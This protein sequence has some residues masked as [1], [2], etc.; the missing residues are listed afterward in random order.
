MCYQYH[1]LRRTKVVSAAGICG[2]RDSS[3]VG[4]DSRSDVCEC[5][6]VNDNDR[7]VSS[8]RAECAG[9]LVEERSEIVSKAWYGRIMPE[10]RCFDE[11]SRGR[12][13][14]LAWI[15]C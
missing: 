4:V 5:E 8:G 6:D 1:M 12:K 15:R 7:M 2:A 11:E 9:E 3:T 14:A 13:L 10:V